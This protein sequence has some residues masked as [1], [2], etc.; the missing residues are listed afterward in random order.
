M[1]NLFLYLLK[2]SVGT[3]IFYI[4]YLLLFSRD[5]FYV[6]NRILLVL[7]LLLPTILPAVKIPIV[8]NNLIPAETEY[9][10]ESMVFPDTAFEMPI[11][12]NVHSFNYNRLFLWIYSTVA[13]LLLE[14]PV[15]LST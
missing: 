1:N 9:A 12:S 8:I 15:K 3:T 2:V 10:I 4:C 6:R 5:K 7:I 13:G 11:I 14:N